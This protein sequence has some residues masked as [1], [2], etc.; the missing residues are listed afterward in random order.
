MPEG[1]Y[2]SV[3][4][5][6]CYL[7]CPRQY[8]LKYV[9]GVPPAFVPVPFAFGTA[10][11]ETAAVMN[12]ELKNTG[13]LPAKAMLAET[14]KDSWTR[15]SSGP[16]PLQADEDDPVVLGAVTDKGVE[17]VEVFHDHVLKT[18]RDIAV[19]AVEMPFRVSIHHPD[20]GEVM[21]EQL[22]GTMDLLVTEGDHRVVVEHK[23]GAKRWSEDQL[24]FDIQPTGYKLAARQAGMGE[25][26]LR[27]QVVTKA[28]APLVQVAELDRSGGDEVDFLRVASGILSA[29]DAGVSYPVRGWTCKGCQFAHACRPGSP[30]LVLV[31]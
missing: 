10:F 25:V 31:A 22:V 2:V 3:S 8:E 11:H 23:T 18:S 4:Q 28:K 6:K 9:K 13:A 19:E 24:R 1:L 26:G 15:A 5:L 17:M 21:E 29:I 16:I 27:L 20:T 14:F 12:S 30:K 7:R